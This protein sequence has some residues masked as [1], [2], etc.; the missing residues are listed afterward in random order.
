MFTVSDRDLLKEPTKRFVNSQIVV[1]GT[2]FIGLITAT[3]ARKLG[4]LEIYVSAGDGFILR[5]RRSFIDPSDFYCS[6][7]LGGRGGGVVVYDPRGYEPGPECS[8]WIDSAGANNIET[9][10]SYQE[11]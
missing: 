1:P 5:L 7:G 11:R 10:I 9:M 3:N 2:T 8:I 6:K 4:L